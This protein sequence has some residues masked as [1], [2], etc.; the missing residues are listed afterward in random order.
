MMMVYYNVARIPGAKQPV[1]AERVI[2][3][4]TTVGE[5]VHAPNVHAKCTMPECCAE[6][7]PK[8]AR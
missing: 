8:I 1:A 3:E 4:K 5:P 7:A 2:M 6:E